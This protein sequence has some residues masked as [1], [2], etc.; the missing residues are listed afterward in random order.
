MSIELIT[1]IILLV[2]HVK[3]D[4]F[5]SKTIFS[6]DLCYY[7]SF[8]LLNYLL[9]LSQNIQKNDMS[10]DLKVE[11]VDLCLE[12]VGILMSVAMILRSI[13]LLVY[14]PKSPIKEISLNPGKIMKVEFIR[15]DKE[16]KK[17]SKKEKE[18]KKKKEIVIEDL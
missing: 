12:V 3:Y 14:S 13:L 7:G 16:E 5:I 8:S 10:N 15:K 17:K 11:T 1:V 18:S 2:T 4:N 6:L 9:I